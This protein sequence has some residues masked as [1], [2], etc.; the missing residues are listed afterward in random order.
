M[1][2]EENKFSTISMEWLKYKKLEVKTSTYI[3]YKKIIKCHLNELYQDKDIKELNSYDY[4]DYFTKLKNNDKL[5]NSMLNS[6]RTVLKGILEFA[7]ERYKIEHIDLSRIKLS[8]TR[9]NATALSDEEAKKLTQYCEE[10]ISFKSVPSYISLYSGMRLGEICGLRW[11]DIDIDNGVIYV[12][13]T[14]ERLEDEEST[15]AKTSLMLLEPKTESSKREIPIVDSLSD[16]LSIYKQLVSGQDENYIITNNDI[17]PDPSTV[18]RRHKKICCLLDIN[19]I[20]FHSLR[21]TFATNCVSK[22]VDYK[23]LCEAMG[24]SNVSITMNVYVHPSRDFK[25]EQ[26]N[27]ISRK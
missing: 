25:K 4:L 2:Q 17:I 10:N 21:H 13:R 12:R 9:T 27:K 26:I 7:E 24:H 1:Q 6:I 11:Q 3:K 5:S 16:Y 20:K 14:V 22:E 15:D 23:V 8:S 18:E 19:I